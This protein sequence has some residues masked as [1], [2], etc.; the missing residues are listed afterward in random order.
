MVATAISS[1][2]SP[3]KSKLLNDRIGALN[4]LVHISSHFKTENNIKNRMKSTH[5]Q[6]YSK[7]LLSN[8]HAFY[9]RCNGV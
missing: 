5:E 7:Q 4:D 9:L 1:I 3:V 6:A 8:L 2:P